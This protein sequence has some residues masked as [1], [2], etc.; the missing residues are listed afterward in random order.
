MSAEVIVIGDDVRI[1]RTLM[2][3]DDAYDAS[4]AT[5]IKVAFVSTDHSTKLTA[6]I[7]Q[8]ENASGAD[9]ANG[10]VIIEMAAAD[11]ADI[12]DDGPA[13]LELQVDKTIKQ[14]WHMA[15]LLVEGQIE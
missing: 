14:T 2:I 4:G 11:T 5:S 7:E 12:T 1:E 13:I 9:W 6:D 3:G 8:D 15:V 10:V